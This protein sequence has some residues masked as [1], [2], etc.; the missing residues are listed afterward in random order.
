[1]QEPAPTQASRQNWKEKERRENA[2]LRRPVAAAG[3]VVAAIVGVDHV[4]CLG[5]LG[6]DD[7]LDAGAH[8]GE[9][10]VGASAGRR[11]PRARPLVGRRRQH[12]GA[13]G[14]AAEQAQ[15]VAL[16][17]GRVLPADGTAQTYSSSSGRRRRAATATPRVSLSSASRTV[18]VA[19]SRCSAGASMGSSMRNAGGARVSSWM[20]RLSRP[21]RCP[22]S[23]TVGAWSARSAR[24]LCRPSIAAILQPVVSMG[25][26]LNILKS[27]MA[28]LCAADP[29][30]PDSFA[31]RSSVDGRSSDRIAAGL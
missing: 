12:P 9:L 19:I 22:N 17:V 11:G 18:P 7:A 27:P 2:Q 13:H 3:G 20:A 14:H 16:V 23:V 30:G 31:R 28:P 8:V 6:P 4:E 10:T 25:R 26:S 29:G 21:R 1:M 15:D 24:L 5:V